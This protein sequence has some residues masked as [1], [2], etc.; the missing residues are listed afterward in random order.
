L[1]EPAYSNPTKASQ[2]MQHAKAGNPP[3]FISGHRDP[4]DTKSSRK[5]ALGQSEFLPHLADPLAD[6][7]GT[8]V[9]ALMI[10][11]SPKGRYFFLV[12]SSL[13]T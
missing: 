6:F 5:L 9:R 8:H 1:E 2:L 12:V 10:D 11:E 4:R 13:D 3:S 7:C